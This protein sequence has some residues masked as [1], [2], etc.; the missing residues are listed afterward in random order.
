MAVMFLLA[1]L[2]RVYSLMAR[3]PCIS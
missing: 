1:F 2:R 3:F